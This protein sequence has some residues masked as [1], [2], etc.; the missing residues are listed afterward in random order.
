MVFAPC[1]LLQADA[2]RHGI[3]EGGSVGQHKTVVH[4]R[5]LSRPPSV[6]VST[7][8]CDTC[9]WS[10]DLDVEMFT[11]DAYGI[12]CDGPGEALDL[13][14][15]QL[16]LHRP[17]ALQLSSDGASASSYCTPGVATRR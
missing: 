4:E 10:T 15:N 13:V 6:A 7:P 17:H 14:A 1:G 8:L 12:G 3:M 16:R 11:G 9:E 5:V 2:V